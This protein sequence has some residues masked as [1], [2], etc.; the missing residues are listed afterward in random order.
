MFSLSK[1]KNTKQIKTKTKKKNT[2]QYLH[3][4]K[5]KFLLYNK[6]FIRLPAEKDTVCVWERERRDYECV[7]EKENVCMC[8]WERLWVCVREKENV[9]VCERERHREACLWEREMCVCLRKKGCVCKRLSVWKRICV[10]LRERNV[11]VEERL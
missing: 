1:N 8:V 5:K 11:C 7:R 4:E 10:H 6:I 9:C 3:K 2:P